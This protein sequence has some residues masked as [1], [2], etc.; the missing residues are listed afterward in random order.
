MR[1]NQI[2]DTDNKTYLIRF[3]NKDVKKVLLL[4]SGSRFHTTDFEWPKNVAPNGFTMKLRKHLKNKRLETLTQLGIDRII[5][6][7]FGVGEAAYHVIVEMYD[8]G[9]II[10]TDCEMIILNILRPHVEGE[11]VR[12]A[13]REKYPECR[14]RDDGK[15][16]EDRLI[17]ILGNAKPGENLKKILNP[18]LR[19]LQNKIRR[20]NSSV[21]IVLLSYLFF[22]S[23][24]TGCY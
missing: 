19:K 16:T 10:L 3:Q 18:I 21:R 11:E 22:S 14:A 20:K 12:F 2:Y 15:I 7:Q 9:N 17:E 5:D 1:V 6:L 23:I 24:W 13:V 8:R 4:E